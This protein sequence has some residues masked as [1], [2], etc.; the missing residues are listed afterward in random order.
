MFGFD[1][2]WNFTACI[3]SANLD[4]I[5]QKIIGLLERE[6][7]CRRILKPSYPTSKLQE[8]GSLYP[9]DRSQDLWIVGLLPGT[10]GWTAIKTWP[11]DLLCRRAIGSDRPRLSTLVMQIGGN[12]F[13]FGV[14]GSHGILL[15]ANATGQILLSGSLDSQ[16]RK[17]YRI[18]DEDFQKLGHFSGFSL[19][20]MPDLIQV[21]MKVERDIELDKKKAQEL[22][23]PL[24]DLS[25]EEIEELGLDLPFDQGE[26]ELLSKAYMIRLDEALGEAICGAHSY[27]Y[28]YNLIYC[29]YVQEQQLEAY[30]ARLL[31]FEPPEHYRQ[32][33]GQESPYEAEID[34]RLDPED[35]IPF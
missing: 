28:L 10:A 26:L 25:I 34:D 7:G 3:H 12:A 35:D 15:E 8:L 29:A 23:Q 18:Y 9:W 24:A 30:G 22:T 16:T 19:L 4:T 13:H 2:Y 21:V 5:E 31:Y 27:W 20:Q 32:S 11:N 33:E 17:K 14:Y 1:R 6:K